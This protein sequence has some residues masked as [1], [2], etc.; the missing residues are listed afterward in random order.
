MM[1][2]ASTT[3]EGREFPQTAL[4]PGI[5]EFVEEG[6]E[7]IGCDSALL[8]PACLTVAAAAIGCSCRVR[9]KTTWSEPSTLW[10]AA[11][12]ESGTLKSPALKL[13][14]RPILSLDRAAHRKFKAELAHYDEELV[15]YKT[16]MKLRQREEDMG[17]LPTEPEQPKPCRVVVSD[18]TIEALCDVLHGSPHGLLLFS[19]ELGGWVSSMTRYGKSKG[20]DV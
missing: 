4:P 14:M 9:L 6:A 18:T 16:A 13:A 1:T 12:S 7:A 10:T 2:I 20:G 3:L 5:R 19:D 15:A 8:A 17:P 11:I